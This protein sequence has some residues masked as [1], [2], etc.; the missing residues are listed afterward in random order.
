MSVGELFV[1]STEDAAAL[2]TERHL[3]FDWELITRPWSA[4]AFRRAIRRR[5]RAFGPDR[6]PTIVLSNHD[7]PRHAS[8]LADSV[9]AVGAD[10]DAIARAAALLTLT[11]RGTPFLYYGE[12]LGM[13]DTAVPPEESVDAAAEYVSSDYV[14]WDRSPARTPMPWTGGPQAGFSAVRPWLRLGD[15]AASRNV[16]VQG[17]DPGSVLACYRRLLAVRA[18]T[19]AL[20]RGALRLIRSGHPDVLAFRRTHR[21]RHGRRG[22]G[23]EVI[24]AVNLGRDPATIRLP[25]P[26]QRGRTWTPTVG[27]K[28]EPARIDGAGTVTL[29]GYEGVVASLTRPDT[30]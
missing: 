6:W 30:S 18:A 10:R 26:R 19:P 11:I 2:T 21:V 23:S 28:P 17:S 5:E 29:A 14:W 8:R 22:E 1:G 3:V 16:A 25:R 7:Q 15:D 13:G 27:T 4:E 9:G 24:V 12:E 20:H